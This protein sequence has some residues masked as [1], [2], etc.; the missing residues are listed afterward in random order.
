MLAEPVKGGE[1]EPEKRTK[2]AA[3]GRKHVRVYTH[4]GSVLWRPSIAALLT[5]ACTQYTL[6]LT[7]SHHTCKGSR[8]AGVAVL[9]FMERVVLFNLQ[10]NCHRLLV[11]FKNSRS[12]G[13]S[14]Q[15]ANAMHARLP[16]F[17]QQS[18]PL[19]G[20]VPRVLAVCARQ[21]LGTVSMGCQTRRCRCPAGPAVSVHRG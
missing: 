11:H 9:P 8:S 16:C 15:R 18:S 7:R 12:N 17:S 14:A 21:P 3:K 13:G 6:P 5:S 19:Q 4:I 1:G 20:A 10:G 2:Q